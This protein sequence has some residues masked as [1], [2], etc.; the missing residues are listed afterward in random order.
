MH[1][2]GPPAML[3]QASGSSICACVLQNEACEL[4][5]AVAL[6]DAVAYQAEF[7]KLPKHAAT[8]SSDAAGAYTCA[9]V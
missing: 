3:G 8:S 6:R 9:C 5:A 4:D 2:Y 1:L 7:L